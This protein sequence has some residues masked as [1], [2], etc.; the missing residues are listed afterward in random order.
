MRRIDA[1]QAEVPGQGLPLIRHQREGVEFGKT[2]RIATVRWTGRSLDLEPDRNTGQGHPH[3]HAHGRFG[4][5]EWNRVGKSRVA[6]GCAR[7]YR[8][9]R[10]LGGDGHRIGAVIGVRPQYGRSRNRV[11]EIDQGVVRKRIFKGNRQIDLVE[12]GFRDVAPK[13]PADVIHLEGDTHRG[14][15]G[16]QCDAGVD[17]GQ[18]QPALDQLRHGNSNGFPDAIRDPAK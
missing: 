9:T 18:V 16:E 15:S 13:R 2:G 17:R 14:K 12:R 6:D 3:V 1:N 8:R 5:R 10:G 11:A 7:P 4:H